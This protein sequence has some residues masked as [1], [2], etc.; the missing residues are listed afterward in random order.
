MASSLIKVLLVEDDEDDFVIAQDHFFHLPGGRFQLD[1]V[2]TYPEAVVEVAK[3]LHDLYVFDYRLGNDNGL[4]LLEEVRAKGCK[5]P[6]IMW[7]R[8]VDRGLEAKAR[9]AGANGFFLKSQ[10]T[11][12]ILERALLTTAGQNSV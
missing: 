12:E 5:N 8:F 1:W 11:P 6:I 2:C 9:R 7:T 3:H 4:D 10:V